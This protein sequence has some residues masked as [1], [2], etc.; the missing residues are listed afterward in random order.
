MKTASKNKPLNENFTQVCV[1][2]ATVVG[3]T[4][5]KIKEFEDWGISEF[6]VRFQYLEEILTNRDESGPGGRNDLFFAVHSEDVGKF[7]IP[8]LSYGIRWIEDVYGNR[9]GHLYPD[10]VAEYKSWDAGIVTEDDPEDD[11]DD[12]D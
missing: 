2:P 6:G 12:E 7:A 9:Q 8:R 4:K 10:R 1:W 11:E 5:K 3:K